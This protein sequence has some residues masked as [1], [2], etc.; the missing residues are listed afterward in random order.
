MLSYKAVFIWI[1]V[2]WHVWSWCTS[3]SYFD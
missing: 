3:V 1:E 2:L